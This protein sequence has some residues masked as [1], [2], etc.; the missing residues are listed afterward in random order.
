M[1]RGSENSLNAPL[2][3]RS[4]T[5][6]STICSVKLKEFPLVVVPC[7]VS[8]QKYES[9]RG[10]PMVQ[11][12]CFLNTPPCNQLTTVGIIATS[13]GLNSPLGRSCWRQDMHENRTEIN[14][15]WAVG[16]ISHT[17]DETA[18]NHRGKHWASPCHRETSAAEDSFFVEG[19]SGLPCGRC[20]WL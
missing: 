6:S 16:S 1:P 18:N 11:A 9:A 14:C 19:Q 10:E 12:P 20:S 13:L 5:L 8:R 7:H 4:I 2:L 17:P 3:S 15:D